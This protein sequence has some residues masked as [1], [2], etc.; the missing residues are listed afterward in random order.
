MGTRKAALSDVT[1][2][3]RLCLDNVVVRHNDIYT[4]L[5]FL[6]VFARFNF[7]LIEAEFS[8][9]VPHDPHHNS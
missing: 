7:A 6:L 3:F 8:E 9:V 1:S 4:N 5:L 2:T